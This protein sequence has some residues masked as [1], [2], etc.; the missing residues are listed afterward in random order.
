MQSWLTLTWLEPLM[1]PGAGLAQGQV[2]KLKGQERKFR[3]SLQRVRWEITRP[4][5]LQEPWQHDLRRK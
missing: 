5:A 3:H 2:R 1:K 4:N